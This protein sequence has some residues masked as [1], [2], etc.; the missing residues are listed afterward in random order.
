MTDPGPS[1]PEV[2][3]VIA[4]TAVAAR[5]AAL[6]RAIA[7]A[8]SQQPQPAVVVVVNG[9]NFDAE[10]YAE[11]ERTP[12]VTLVY[13]EKA[14]YPAAQR[15]GRTRVTTRYFCFLDDDDELLPGSVG[16]RLRYGREHP[17]ADI[18][19]AHG[20]RFLGGRDE[21][22]CDPYPPAPGEVLVSLLR[23]NWFASPAALFVSD[24]V[25]P[26]YFD[27]E[28]KYFEWTVIAF[29]LAHAGR[30]FGFIH[31]FG[32]RLHES[33]VSLSKEAGSTLAVPDVLRRLL[34]LAP[35]ANA[36]AELKARLARAY[37]A[38]S[39]LELQRGNRLAAWRHHLLSLRSLSGLR[40][41]SYT[42]HLLC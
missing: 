12:G 33:P 17:D 21:A 39:A 38:C 29:R 26:E 11:L 32:Y 25:G 36:R 1:A 9:K 6:R 30:R 7:S 40:Y 2:T 19:V 41:L 37:N 13:S 14:S 34:R 16:A 23:Q 22:L 15:T 18:I 27:G 3:V 4:T 8:L 35:P 20:Y 42:R 24:R 31:D 28:T 10:T 5:R